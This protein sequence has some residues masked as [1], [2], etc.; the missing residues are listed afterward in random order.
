MQD[1]DVTLVHAE[2]AHAASK[3]A[4]VAEG[5]IAPKFSPKTVTEDRPEGATLPVAVEATGPSNE[6]LFVD[7]PAVAATVMRNVAWSPEPYT[8]RHTSDVRE[9]HANVLQLTVFNNADGV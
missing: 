5:S 2:V 6:K 9:F 8:G 4:S 1:T 3:P 7:V